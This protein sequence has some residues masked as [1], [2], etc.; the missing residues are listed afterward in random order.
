MYGVSA[1]GLPDRLSALRPSVPDIDLLY[2]PH[3]SLIPREGVLLY[4]PEHLEKPPLHHFLG[5]RAAHLRRLRTASGREL[6]Y[7]GRVEAA[8]LDELQ[9]LFVVPLRLAGV[10][11]YDVGA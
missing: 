1:P 5:D 9:G 3:L 7:V 10:T 11:D 4:S 8:V 6:D 2:T